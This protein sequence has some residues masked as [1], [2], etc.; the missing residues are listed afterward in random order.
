MSHPPQYSP[1]MPPKRDAIVE[2]A[3][4][5]LA[6]VPAALNLKVTQAMMETGNRILQC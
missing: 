3:T 6:G 2:H 5:L 1:N 4:K